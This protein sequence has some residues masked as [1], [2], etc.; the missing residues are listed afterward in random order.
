MKGLNQMIRNMWKA[1]KKQNARL[2]KKQEFAS[3]QGLLVYV[4]T[5]LLTKLPPDSVGKY[6]NDYGKRE[7]S[8]NFIE[9]S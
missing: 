4:L 5:R 9:R 1:I 3:T 7:Y 2:S 8:L 6:S